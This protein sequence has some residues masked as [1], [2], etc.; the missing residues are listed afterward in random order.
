MRLVPDRRRGRGRRR[1]SVVGRRPLPRLRRV[2]PA[3][4]HARARDAHACRPRLGPRADRGRDRAPSSSSPPARAPRSRTRRSAT[5]TRSRSATCGSRRSRRPGTGPSTSPTSSPTARAAASRRRC[6]RATRCSSATW[7]GPTSPSPSS[8]SSRRRARCTTRC[9]GSPSL[10]DHVELWPG[11]IGGS[12]C[13]GTGTSEKPSSTIGFERRANRG[14]VREPERFVD[15]L[16]TRLPEP[17]PTVAQVVELNRGPLLAGP[18]PLL[19]LAPER[20]AQLLAEGAAVVD[21]RSAPEFDRAAIPGSLCLPLDRPG[22]GTKAAWLLEPGRPVVVVAADDCAGERLAARLAAVGIA[23]RVGRLAGG[24][25]AWAAEPRPLASRSHRRRQG[26]RPAARAGCRRA[27]RRPRRERARRRSGAGRARCTSRGARA[28]PAPPRRAPT[29]GRSSSP[30]PRARA[31]RPRRASSCTPTARPCSASP[32]GG[33]AERR[34]PGS[35][36]PGTRGM[37]S[38][39]YE[40]ELRAGARGRRRRA[41]RAGCCGAAARGGPR[42]APW[43]LALPAIALLLAFHFVAQAEGAWYAFTDWDGVSPAHWVGLDNFRH[44]WASDV[45]RGALW[46]SL[47][48]AAA[49]VVVVNALGLDARARPQPD[50]EVAPPA[51][52][53]VLP[54][55]RAERARERLHLAVHL[56]L[57]RRAQPVPRRRRPRRVAA[58]RGSAIPTGRSGRSSSRWSGSSPGSRW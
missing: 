57:P 17:P 15:E 54:A 16:L 53:A 13:C 34:A 40:R 22:V 42:R 49:F 2:A 8:P 58:A 14:L 29:A 31:R 27:G 4:H 1:R 19:P 47:K 45:Q 21:G 50:G 28:P 12:L 24:I 48:L 9:G 36:A 55:G 38:Q 7:R 5:A 39:P 37:T 32:T 41:A 43:L 6:S 23:S 46:N 11:H 10:P 35:T 26:R 3:A 30:V 44:I 20:V 51:A 25:E 56:R 18:P 33:A 52:L